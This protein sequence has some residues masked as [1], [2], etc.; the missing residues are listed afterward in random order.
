MAG[1]P[2][3]FSGVI[4]PVYVPDVRPPPAPN[5]LQVVATRPEELDRAI[6]IEW[7]QPPD[8]DV[9]FDIEVR[10]AGPFV[11]A[12][13]VP[14][15]T[16][17]PGGR[18]RFVHAERVPGRRYEYR[19]VS[20][21][22]ALDP[23]D[24]SATVRRDIRSLP[25]AVR[26]GVAISAFPPAP[27]TDLTATWDGAS[28]HLTWTNGEPYDAVLVHRRPPE[29][30]GFQRVGALP[31]TAAA[32]DDAAVSSGT[33]AYEVRARTASREARSTIVEV[34]VP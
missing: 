13:Q 5:L 30:F 24:P 1:V 32:H 22:E 26:P 3:T 12:G 28:V 23:I 21:R 9:R 6:A 27:P 7:S 11:V 10:E 18:F 2:S 31:G 17:A 29:R 8:P 19:V 14:R 20:V 33:W 34:T 15:G 25:S 16:S 4:G